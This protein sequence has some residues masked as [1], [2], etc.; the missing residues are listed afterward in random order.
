MFCK[1]CGKEMDENANFCA[2]CGAK[3]EKEQPPMQEAQ[4][5]NCVDVDDVWETPA[6]EEVASADAV[7]TAT[8]TQEEANMQTNDIALIGFVGAFVDPILGCVFGAIGLSRAMKRKGKGKGFAIAALAIG[9]A[10][11]L[12][13]VMSSACYTCSQLMLL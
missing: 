4:T 3:L 9:A 11:F 10:S 5:Q 2:N 8:P 12:L 1:Q 6:Q 7:Q 13:S